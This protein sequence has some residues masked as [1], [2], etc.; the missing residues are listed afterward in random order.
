MT[1]EVM[2]STMGL[3]FGLL[4]STALYVSTKRTCWW[5]DNHGIWCAAVYVRN[6]VKITIEMRVLEFARWICWTPG[7][8]T[9]FFCASF[10]FFS[11]T[12]LKSRIVML[13]LQIVQLNHVLWIL[14]GLTFGHLHHSK[15]YFNSRCQNFNQQ[16]PAYDLQG[17]QQQYCLSANLSIQY[18][19]FGHKWKKLFV[20]HHPG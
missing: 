17:T 3:L 15:K 4:S 20:A 19:L 2:C 14:H 9:H 16:C 13:I 10:F 7:L 5:S 1:S 8:T 18:K 6:F 11:F 12:A